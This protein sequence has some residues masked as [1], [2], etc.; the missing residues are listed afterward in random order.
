MDK[1]IAITIPVRKNSERVPNKMLRPFAGSS[2]FE[3]YLDKLENLKELVYIVAYEQEF[4]DIAEK[5]GFKVQHRNEESANGEVSHIIHNYL[6]DMNEDFIVMCTA[7]CPL[8]KPETIEAAVN[9]VKRNHD[10]MS[11]NGFISVKT[12]RNVIWDA[13]QK[14]VNDDVRTFNTKRR[15]SLFIETSSIF[16]FRRKRFVELGCYWDFSGPKDPDLFIMD[17]REGLDVDTMDDFELAEILYERDK[18]KD[19]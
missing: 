13:Y 11:F 19:G 15:K 5:R 14:V 2:L 7:C 18:K 3:V 17:G 9:I 4:K 12:C 1:T 10:M 16:V 8:M 6:D